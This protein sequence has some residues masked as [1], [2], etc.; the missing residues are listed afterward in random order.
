MAIIKGQMVL[1]AALPAQGRP[2]P[3]VHKAA[4]PVEWLEKEIHIDFPNGREIL[5]LTISSDD[6]E[7]CKIL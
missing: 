7:T 6:A 3:E 1:N 2:T 4:D 5:H